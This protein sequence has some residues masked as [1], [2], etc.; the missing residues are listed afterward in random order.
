MLALD[1]S[2][3]L[4]LHNA[5]IYTLFDRQPAAQALAIKDG[6]IVAVGADPEIQPLAGPATQRIDLAGRTVLPGVFDSHNHLLQVGVKLTRLRLDE[7]RS[8]AEMMDLVRARAAETP[9][10]HWIV[11]E[12]WN[13]G[14]FSDAT[15]RGRVPTRWDIDPATDQHPVILMRFFNTDVVNSVALRLAG[16]TRATPD[17]VGGEIGR[18]AAREPNG[19]LRAAAKLLVRNLLPQPTLGEL[20]QAIHLGCQEMNRY[21]ITSVLDP[22]LYPYE[23]AAYQAVV[24]EGRVARGEGRPAVPVSVRLNLMPSW[25][26]FREEETEAELEARARGLGI[27][28]GLGDEWLRLGGLKMAI[29]GGTSSHTAWMHAPFEGETHVGDFNRLDP[30]TLRRHFHTAQELGWDVGIHTCGDRA[31]D[32]VVDAFAAVARNTPR[33]DARHNVIHA[34]FPSE[35]AL[36][37]MAEHRI[38]AVIQPTFLYWEGD[39]IFR[40][41]GERRAANYKP[42]RRYLDHGVV[43]CATSDIPSTVSPDPFAGLYALVTRK[44]NLGH[45]VA[46]DQAI[47]REEALRAYTINGTWL[48][49]EEALKGTLAPGKLADLIVIDRDYF[50]VPDDAIKEIQVLMTMVGGQIVYSTM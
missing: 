44:N 33:P 25:H 46:P 4:I 21:G 28:S 48:T 12:G 40:D 24:A 20:K 16:I 32:T 5:N 2:P 7:C 42:A 49:R 3:D 6:R 8:P 50:T 23:I 18:D 26:G 47:S 31:M 39:L 30:Q 27:A 17:P 34:Y 10:G 36:T 15:P 35:R 14:N 45:C 1:L 38:A 29:D 13:E 41:V 19:L 37:Q 43:L 9:P 22:G 11:G